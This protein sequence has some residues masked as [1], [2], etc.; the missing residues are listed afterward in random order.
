MRRPFLW[1]VLIGLALVMLVLIARRDAGTV[2]G[3]AADD[4]GALAY[5]LA[6]IALIGGA[7]LVMFRERFAKALETALQALIR[8][9][10][11]LNMSVRATARPVR[12]QKR[13]KRA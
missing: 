3:L 10:V 11:A 2:A 6:L 1:I 4:F 12:S 9:A 5:Y 7:V 8:A 13:P